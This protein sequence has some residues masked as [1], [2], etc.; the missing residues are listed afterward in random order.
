MIHKMV[1]ERCC[2]L[3]VHRWERPLLHWVRL[4]YLLL[5]CP[6]CDIRIAQTLSLN[7][8]FTTIAASE[9]FSLS[10]SKTKALMQAF[11]R[12][13]DIRIKEEIELFKGEVVKI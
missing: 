8:P 1:Q 4:C 3:D 9:V 13:V 12:N 6:E 7:V 11:R 10:M 2:L 5:L